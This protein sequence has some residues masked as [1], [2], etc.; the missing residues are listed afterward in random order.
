MG[1]CNEFTHALIRKGFSNKDSEHHGHFNL[2]EVDKE[3]KRLKRSVY[4]PEEKRV[5]F[6]KKQI[7]LLSK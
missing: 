4:M 3:M 7:K 6:I 1:I 5:P 2:P